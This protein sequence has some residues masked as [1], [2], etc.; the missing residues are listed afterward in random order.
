[1]LQKAPAMLAAVGITTKVVLQQ[2][3]LEFVGQ[4]AV[5]FGGN[6]NFKRLKPFDHVTFAAAHHDDGWI[7]VD[8]TLPLD[9]TRMP[10]NLFSTPP[11]T[12]AIVGPKSADV[13][14]S[15]HPYAELLISMH[16]TGLQ[17]GRYGVDTRIPAFEQMKEEAATANKGP[18]SDSANDPALKDRN[19]KFQQ[20]EKAR[21][22]EIISRISKDPETASWVSDEALWTNFRAIQ[23]FD[24]LALYFGL[25]RDAD[26]G[27]VEFNKVPTNWT[28]DTD[29]TLTRVE[30]GVYALSPY[31]FDQSPLVVTMPGTLV[32]PDDIASDTGDAI[33]RGTPHTESIILMAGDVC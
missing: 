3:H 19:A 8:P 20:E 7:E 22:E 10:P 6:E 5:H 21:Q 18:W 25:E 23:F 16:H 32:G 31:P 14:A 26:R 15:Y 13:G 28:S 30:S 33:S 12:G 17:H 9:D 1:M 4:L 24:T 29:V 27:T 11:G 2:Q